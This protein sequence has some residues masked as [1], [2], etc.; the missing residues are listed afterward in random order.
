M[1]F[2]ERLHSARREQGM[3]QV[4]FAERLGVAPGTVSRWEH[5]HNVPFGHNLNA[6][7]AALNVTPEWLAGEEEPGG[8]LPALA[9]DAIEQIVASTTSDVYVGL[10]QVLRAA[11][12]LLDALT[13]LGS[14]ATPSR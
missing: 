14:R 6:I 5:G 13:E 4:E 8:E 2:H 9:K 12:D 10:A 1:S 11:A 7:A 3:S